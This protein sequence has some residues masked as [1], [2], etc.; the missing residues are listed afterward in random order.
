[1]KRTILAIA[2][3]TLIL[4]AWGCGTKTVTVTK[5]VTPAPVVTTMAPAPVESDTPVPV[6]TTVPAP[7]TLDPGITAAVKLANSAMGYLE[8]SINELNSNQAQAI[9]DGNRA[10]ALFNRS[11]DMWNQFA[12]LD[13]KQGVL[14]HRFILFVKQAAAKWTAAVNAALAGDVQTAQTNAVSCDYARGKANSSYEAYKNY[15]NGVNSF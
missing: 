2:V 4:F 15:V 9:R 11:A 10:N 7:V 14:A 1:M 8:A 12:T 3:L 6:D 5:T 13:T